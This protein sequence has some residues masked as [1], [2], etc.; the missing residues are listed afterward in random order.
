MPGLSSLR[1]FR[2]RK[3]AEKALAEIIQD[4]GNPAEYRI[5]K[6]PSGGFVIA[7]LDDDGKDVMGVID[8]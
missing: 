1:Q 2:L 4:G 8:S 6:H 7:V 3:Y 5:E